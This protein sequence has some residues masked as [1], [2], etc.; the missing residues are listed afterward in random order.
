MPT[1]EPLAMDTP[2]MTPPA[3]APRLPGMGGHY[4]ASI[5]GAALDNLFRQVAGVALVAL[6]VRQPPGDAVKAEALGSLYTNL[7]ALLF[8]AP[9]LLLGP[10]A[11]SLGDRL[12][13]H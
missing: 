10:L 1:Q 8:I 12:A 6:A 9:F 13:K 4:Q 5:T 7:S 2:A 11:G 3:P